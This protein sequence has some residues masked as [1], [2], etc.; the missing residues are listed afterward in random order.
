[1]ICCSSSIRPCRTLEIKKTMVSR[2]VQDVIPLLKA[3][4]IGDLLGWTGS[5]F[6]RKEEGGWASTGAS[7][8]VGGGCDDGSNAIG[9]RS[10]ASLWSGLS[11]IDDDET[12]TN[13]GR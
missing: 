12:T 13:G 10:H 5:R 6:V 2:D 9:E 4:R 7:S 8:V 3:G 11:S 1:M